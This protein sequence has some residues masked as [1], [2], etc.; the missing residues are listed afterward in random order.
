M[1]MKIEIKE[2]QMVFHLRD[3]LT[4]KEFDDIALAYSLSES[5]PD[6]SKTMLFDVMNSVTQ[7]DLENYDTL[8]V[9]FT[10][11]AIQFIN[12]KFIDAASIGQTDDKKKRKKTKKNDK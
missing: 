2:A 7:E 4:N 9:L 12:Q 1:D 3:F 10:M 8:P 11:R 5:D 6:K